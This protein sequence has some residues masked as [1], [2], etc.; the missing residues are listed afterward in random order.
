[1]SKYPKIPCTKEK[2][3]NW[4]MHKSTFCRIHNPDLPPC[5]L[6]PGHEFGKEHWFKPG[7]KV[8]KE[9]W[10]KPGNNY[11]FQPG[12]ELSK[13][14]SHNRKHG[15][16]AKILTE[17]EKEFLREAKEQPHDIDFDEIIALAELG[18]TRALKS[19]EVEPLYKMLSLLTKIKM[20]QFKMNQKDEQTEVNDAIKEILREI[21]LGERDGPEI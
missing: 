14:F 13:G 1:M 11:G 5:G 10:F 18:L 3:R 20:T 17:E 4:A 21:G 8:G 12:N 16:Y 9:H 15:F 7:H 2:C 19:G 6:Q